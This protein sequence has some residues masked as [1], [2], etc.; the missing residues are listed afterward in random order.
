MN[1]DK[2]RISQ[3]FILLSLIVWLGGIIF[4][5]AVVAPSVFGVL[6]PVEGGRHLAG[7]I[8]NR[9]LGALHWM[10]LVCGVVFLVTSTI[11]DK[12][13]RLKQQL[14]VAMMLLTAALQFAITPRLAAVR[15]EAP[16]LELASPAQRA[17]FDRLHRLSTMTEGAVLLLGLGVV[18]LVAKE[19]RG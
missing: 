11:V 12:G 16:Q 14:V 18:G 1:A 15:A 2:M 4:F 10:G 9:S 3:F 6:T 17:D 7:E 13:F 19:P 8:V 5:S